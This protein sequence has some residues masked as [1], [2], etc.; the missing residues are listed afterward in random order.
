MPRF[1]VRF[2]IFC[3]ALTSHSRKSIHQ[4]KRPISVCA[5]LL[6]FPK[7]SCR[8]ACVFQDFPERSRPDLLTAVHRNS[9][10]SAIGMAVDG[11]APLLS[12]KI[13]AEFLNYSD[14]F[15][16]PGQSR[17][18]RRLYTRTSTDE[19]LTGF[20]NGTASFSALRSSTWSW[21]T[22]RMFFSAPSNDRPWV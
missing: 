2:F 11:V 19:K 1:H 22:S 21:T 5:L 15:P 13:K 18:N 14:D 7:L 8:N 20:R 4:F 9:N 16:G 10:A 12:C 3:P 6:N 17:H